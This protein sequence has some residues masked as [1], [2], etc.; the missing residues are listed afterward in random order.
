MNSL[1]EKI[2]KAREEGFVRKFETLFNRF[3]P[4]SVFRYSKGDIFDFDIERLKRNAS[5]LPDDPNLQII[6]LTNGSDDD[7]RQ[8]LKSFTWSSIPIEDASDDLG[9]AIIDKRD[10]DRLLAGLWAAVDSFREYDLGLKFEFKPNQAWLYCAFVDRNVRGR[11]IYKRLISNVAADLDQRGFSELFG[12]VQPWNKI[13]WHTHQKY[14]S[15]IVGQIAAIKVGP[16]AKVW[17][18]GQTVVDKSFVG[19]PGQNPCR[20]AIC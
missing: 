2:C 6:C 15:R 17:N 4:S 7:Q 20:I 18:S 13:S 19:D 12:I 11:G 14:S 16:S 9:Y 1:A 3:V 10:P 5:D 8:Q